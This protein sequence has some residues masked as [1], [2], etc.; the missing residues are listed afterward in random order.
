MTAPSGQ[1]QTA[2]ETDQRAFFRSVEL[3]YWAEADGLKPDERAL[4]GA[5]LDP[6]ARTL[7]A[8]TGGGRLLLQMRELGFGDLRGFDFAPELVDEARRRDADAVIAFDHADATGLPYPDAFFTQAL[9]LQQVLCTIEDPAGRTAAIAE[10][11]RV[12]RPGGVALFSFVCIEARRSSRLEGAYLRYLRVLR[13]I[14]R[15][16]RP[17]Q[18]MPRLK[19]RGRMNPGA[20]ADRGPYTYWYRAKEAE[21]ALQAAGFKVKAIGTTKDAIEGKMHPEAN[22]L[23]KEELQGTLYTVCQLSLIHI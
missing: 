8:G 6:S 11:H 22:E 14:L 4:I 15:S 23:T 13:A 2:A 12:L 1:G 5:Q 10:A 19:L 21:Q 9:Y 20:L 18:L 17:L 3:G 16:S 7:E